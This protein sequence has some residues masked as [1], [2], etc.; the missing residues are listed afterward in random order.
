MHSFEIESAIPFGGSIPWLSVLAA[1][2]L[3]TDE[4]L[5]KKVCIPPNQRLSISFV[6]QS[7][8]GRQHHLTWLQPALSSPAVLLARVCEKERARQCLETTFELRSQESMQ[9]L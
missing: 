8:L 3:A 1:T 7:Y 9:M 4:L 5:P 2:M 6:V